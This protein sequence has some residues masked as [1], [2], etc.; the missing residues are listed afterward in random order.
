MPHGTSNAI[1]L[2]PCLKYVA[3]G[4]VDRFAVLAG[5]QERHQM[6][7]MMLQQQKSLLRQCRN[8]AGSAASET[9]CYGI[10]KK[11]FRSCP[12]MAEDAVASGSPANTRKKIQKEDIIK[13]YQALW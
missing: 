1:L 12:K 9:R 6:R 11:I 7:T 13:I 2:Y 4:A 5:R 10:K 8:Y 3:D